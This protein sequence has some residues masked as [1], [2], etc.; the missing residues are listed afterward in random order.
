[1]TAEE[2]FQAIGALSGLLLILL[3]AAKRMGA[4]NNAPA[5]QAS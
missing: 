1:M 3:P 5:V 2:F 4:R